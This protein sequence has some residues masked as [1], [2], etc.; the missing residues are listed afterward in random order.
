[1]PSVENDSEPDGEEMS[2]D[3]DDSNQSSVFCDSSA[4]H[5]DSD[6]SSEMDENE[7]ERR[8]TECLENLVDLERQFYLLKEQLYKERVIQMDTKLGEVKVGKS[9]E[10]LI[11]LERLKENMKIKVEVA[12]ILKQYRLQNIRNKFVAEEQAALQNFESE[13]EL[14][15]DNIHCDLQEKIRRLEEDRNNVDIHT[16][17]WLNSSGRRRRNYSDKRRAVSVAGP[18]IVYMLNDADILEDWALI[19]KSLSSRKAEIL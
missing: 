9:E 14:V 13:K 18:Y 11:P 3:S 1:M 10:Y 19:K 7:C 12:G 5:S 4:E 8:R 17:L 15:Y 2:H 6:D 16:D